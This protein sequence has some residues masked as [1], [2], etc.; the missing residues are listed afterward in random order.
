MKDLSQLKLAVSP[1][2]SASTRD[3][4]RCTDR[5]RITGVGSFSARFVAR[6]LSGYL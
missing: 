5:D 4:A 1:L 3:T 6:G 2:F